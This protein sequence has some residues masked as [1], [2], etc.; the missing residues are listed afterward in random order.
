M[1][2][3]TP[4]ELAAELSNAV[5]EA[6]AS[7]FMTDGLSRALSAIAEAAQ[8]LADAAEQSHANEALFLEKLAEIEARL[9]A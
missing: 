5:T 3:K 8:A 9:P 4:A 1:Q 2:N 7:P 6:V